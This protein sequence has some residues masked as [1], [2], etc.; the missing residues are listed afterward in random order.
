LRVY[1]RF[2]N[3]G[4]NACLIAGKA[5]EWRRFVE[6]RSLQYIYIYIYIHAPRAV[7]MTYSVAS[8]HKF[9]NS[10]R[11][12]AL[13]STSAWLHKKFARNKTL[14]NN[15]NILLYIHLL[16]RLLESDV[17]FWNTRFEHNFESCLSSLRLARDDSDGGR[18]QT[19]RA[20]TSRSI[21]SD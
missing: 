13:L 18:P 7:N 17:K 1:V 21:F 12:T 6:L 16:S 19:Q 20:S 3:N 9:N 4:N 15:L 14:Q 8:R 10:S 2:W 11:Y 5:G